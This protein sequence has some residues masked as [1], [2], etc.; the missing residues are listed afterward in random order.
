M[1]PAVPYGRT[2]LT[3]EC[4]KKEYN[5]EYPVPLFLRIYNDNLLSQEAMVKTARICSIQIEPRLM[6]KKNHYVCR[7][8]TTTTTPWVRSI[9]RV[10]SRG[11]RTMHKMKNVQ[12][13][14]YGQL[15][16]PLLLVKVNYRCKLLKKG[17]RGILHYIPHG[18]QLSWYSLLMVSSLSF[19]ACRH[20]GFF[21]TL[22]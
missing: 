1:E 21:S 18:G 10:V 15:F 11:I 9:K 13:N 6:W 22:I 12:L 14:K 8:K 20:N 7:R 16:L 17:G 19:S 2:I 3:T 5:G 4:L